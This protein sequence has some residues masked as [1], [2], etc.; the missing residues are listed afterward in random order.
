M[1]KR[2]FT[3]LLTI[4]SGMF[5]LVLLLT[6]THGSFD[7]EANTASGVKPCPNFSIN[8]TEDKICKGSAF[9]IHADST[10]G[11]EIIVMCPW[12]SATMVILIIGAVSAL[13]Y[14]ISSIMQRKQRSIISGKSLLIIGLAALGI[15]VLSGVL[16]LSDVVNGMSK[17]EQFMNDLKAFNF[18]SNSTACSTAVFNITLVFTGISLGFLAYEIFLGYQKYKSEEAEV[19]SEGVF[20]TSNTDFKHG[21]FRED[22]E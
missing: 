4:T 9:V 13:V 22:D 5:C 19:E 2:N 3:L 12:S 1:R 21:F 14:T 8:E 20:L 18:D 6:A 15:L 17:C 11:F 10:N 16:M 7:C